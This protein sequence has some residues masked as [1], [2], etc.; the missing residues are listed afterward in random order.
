MERYTD[1]ISGA[2]L[3]VDIN[4]SGKFYYKDR[5]MTIRHRLDGPAI[6]G[7]SGSKAWWVDGKQH[8]LDGPA[9]EGANGHKEWMVNGKRHRL[10]GPAVEGASGYKEWWV[11]EL[12]IIQTNPDGKIIGKMK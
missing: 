4:K 10:D 1:T 11:N 9:Y 12:F 7:A 8:R 6:E 3:Y 2:E 5:G